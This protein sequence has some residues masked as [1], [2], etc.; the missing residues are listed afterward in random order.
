MEIEFDLGTLDLRLKSTPS[1]PGTFVVF[2]AHELP[3]LV[4]DPSVQSSHIT[5]LSHLVRILDVQMLVQDYLLTT[6]CFITRPRTFL[7]RYSA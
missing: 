5:L 3:V 1:N 4:P 7:N 6:A 2:V